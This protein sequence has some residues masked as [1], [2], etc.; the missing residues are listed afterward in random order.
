MLRNLDPSTLIASIVVLLVA[1]PLHEF[2]HAWTATRFG[3]NT[4]RMHGRL[5]LN[6]LAHLDPMGSLLL[7]FAGFGWAKP[8]PVNPYVLERR[9]P[10]AMMWVSLAGPLTNF[11]LAILAAIPF[12]LGLVSVAEGLAPSVG[13]LPSIDKI[14]VWFIYIN[15]LLTL[16][17]LIPLAPLDGEKIASYFL[18]PNIGRFMDTIRPYG[19][20]ILLLLVFGGSLLGLD[21][22]GRILGPP[23][24][25][26]FGVL[27][28]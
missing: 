19:P 5:T 11:L 6:P 9:S 26:L 20:M 1:F 25:F 22:L 17:N 10:A 13:L 21:L 7:L 12:R 27:V 15:L 18:P 23:L 14:M 16:F 24:F 28:G 4:P 3:D 8:V 2:A